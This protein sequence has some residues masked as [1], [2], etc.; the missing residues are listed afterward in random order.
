M[1]LYKHK[2]STYAEA[3][4]ILTDIDDVELYDNLFDRVYKIYKYKDS[5]S[6][7]DHDHAMMNSC[8]PCLP[9]RKK[10]KNKNKGKK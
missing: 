10:Y 9:F 4:Q 3:Q 2:L 6:S 7:D 8:L 1:Y 5:N